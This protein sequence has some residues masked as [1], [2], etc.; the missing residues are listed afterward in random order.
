M[1]A[2]FLNFASPALY[3]LDASDSAYTLGLVS[4]FMLYSSLVNALVCATA[5]TCVL[6]WGLY[7]C[8]GVLVVAVLEGL[9]GVMV[10]I[11]TMGDEA[12][13]IAV[14]GQMGVCGLVVGVYAMSKCGRFKEW[15][16]NASR[17]FRR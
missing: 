11:M 14:I 15:M 6:R 9:G 8:V 12:L 7:A 17:F 13:S 2:L 10:F 1:L 5:A 16:V 4:R 3:A